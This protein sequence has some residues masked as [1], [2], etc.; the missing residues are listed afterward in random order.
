MKEK[1]TKCDV[2][3]IGGGLAGLTT[4]IL[5]NRQRLSVYLIEKKKYPFHRVCGEYISNEVRN[6]LEINHIF[7][8]ELKPSTI[9]KFKLSSVGG[10]E[11]QVELDLGGFGI[12]RYAFDNY[13]YSIAS[14]EGVNFLFD[15]ALSLSFDN[16]QFNVT[17]KFSGI[18]NAKLVVGAHGKRSKLDQKLNREFMH[19]K[20]PY[21]G[22][23]YHIKYEYPEDI[24]ELHNFKGGYCGINAIEDNKLNLCYLTHRDNLRKHQDIA[25]MEKNILYKNPKLRQIF[26][27]AEFLFEKPEVINEIS[28]ETKNPVENHVLMV[29]DSSGM[30]APLCGNGM[31]MAIHGAKIISEE[32]TNYFH[33]HLN[34]NTL[35]KNYSLRWNEEFRLRLSIGRYTQKLF[36]GTLQ[37]N[38]AVNLLSI[39]PVSRLIIKLTHGR[40]IR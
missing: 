21:I 28:F 23:K 32:I 35:E 6:F 36:G 3:V 29:G 9:T 2:V 31:A 24:I 27:E 11:K 40:P 8:N 33:N 20:S 16:D 38:F 34:R 10:K 26:N 15:E 14:D 13:L 1:E 12:S 4:A 17:S 37:S 18:I 5:L 22:V 39:M 25:T 7:P 30:I 19:K